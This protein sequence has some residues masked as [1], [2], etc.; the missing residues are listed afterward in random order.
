MIVAPGTG[1]RQSEQSSSDGVDMILPLLG[2]HF[3]ITASVIL[4]PQANEPQRSVLQRFARR[5]QIGGKLQPNE[6]V[7]GH[8]VVERLDRP[9]SIEIRVGIQQRASVADDVS[10]IFRV[11]RNV[12]PEP[13]QSLP[14]MR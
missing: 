1:D 12:Q 6:I 13:R 3:R 4:R 9:V 2:H 7:I 5:D 14:E 10:L 11:T 8:V